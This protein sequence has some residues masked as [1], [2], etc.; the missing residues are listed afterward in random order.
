METE[1]ITLGGNIRLAGFRDF[2]KSDMFVV[3]KLV[4]SYARKISDDF[5]DYQELVVTA[6][7]V[8]GSEKHTGRVEV[9][10]RLT[11]TSGE[12]FVSE[13]VDMNLFSSLDGAF[14]SLLAQVTSR[15][16]KD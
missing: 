6:K 9:H 16:R 14:K 1:D 10:V 12:L 7:S 13:E 2:G 15:L 5:G 3:R 8:H 11:L 4:G